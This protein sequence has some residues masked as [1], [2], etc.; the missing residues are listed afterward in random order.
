MVL[1]S[2]QLD[3]ECA[4]RFGCVQRIRRGCSE[5]FSWSGECAVRFGRKTKFSSFSRSSK[6]FLSQIEGEN[7]AGNQDSL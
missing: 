2:V 5:V 1:E 3:G 7:I 4:V 6:I